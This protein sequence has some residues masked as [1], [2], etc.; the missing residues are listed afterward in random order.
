MAKTSEDNVPCMNDA[1]ASLGKLT[2][3]VGVP[4]FNAEKTIVPVVLEA[5]RQ[6]HIV[7]VCDDGSSDMTGKI[8]AQLGAVVVTHPENRGYG[9]AIR[10]LFKRAREL[11]ADVLV[12]LDSDGQHN[13]AE[14]PQIV[15][16]VEDGV[17]DVVLGSRFL[18]RSGTA[19]M[20]IYKKIGVK[21]I[22]RLVNGSGK[23]RVSDAQCGF[24]AYS[25]HALEQLGA[26]SENGMGA[27][28]EL[29]HA[30]RKRGLRVCEV[31]VSCK[32]DKSLGVK[33]STQNPVTHGAGI[34]VTLAKLVVDDRPLTFLGVPGIL[35]L[36]VGSLFGVWL[37]N[38]Y[39]RTRAVVTSIALAS[40]AFLLLGLI[41]VSTGILLYAMA[42]LT[43][44]INAGEKNLSSD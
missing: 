11:N 25:K 18:E 3:V 9:A 27:S 42:R 31:S 36:I 1:Q 32:Y 37:L 12:T 35:S 5:Q 33:T 29:L 6:A 24:R 8:A 34:L 40:F 16:P 30:A 38:A 41:A 28:I 43:R 7:L 4:A 14:V 19:E 17:A 10:S 26:F 23:R 13:P 21:V 2:V 44:R 20:P 15:K 22:T 39:A